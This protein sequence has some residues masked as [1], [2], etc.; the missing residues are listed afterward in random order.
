MDSV[1]SQL[2][3]WQRELLPQ[4]VDRLARETPDTVYAIWPPVVDDHEALSRTISYAQFAN[5]INGLV[6]FL[7][8]QLGHGAGQVLTYI[9]PND[10]RLTALVLASIKAGY[11]VSCPSSGC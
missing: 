10:V 4:M 3:K 6:R 7:L 5:V 8:K 2:S 1:H 9:G 11:T